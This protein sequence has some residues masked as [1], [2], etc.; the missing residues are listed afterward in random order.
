VR[1]IKREEE[2]KRERG[3]RER[4]RKGGGKREG[5][6]G[7]ETRSMVLYPISETGSLMVSPQGSSCTYFLG[8][9]S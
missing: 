4:R 7:R 5:E 6:R 3:R 9:Y 8:D 1:D 2:G